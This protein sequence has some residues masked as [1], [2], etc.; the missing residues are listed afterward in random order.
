MIIGDEVRDLVKTQ[1]YHVHQFY[2][3]NDKSGLI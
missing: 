2:C 3:E 1:R